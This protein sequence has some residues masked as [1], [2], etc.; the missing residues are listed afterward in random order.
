MK[1]R[2]RRWSR[3]S[4]VVATI[5]AATV[6]G[7]GVA[8]AATAQPAITTFTPKSADQVTNVDV[9]RQHYL[10]EVAAFVKEQ[11]GA[12]CV[13]PRRKGFYLRNAG[14]KVGAGQSLPAGYVHIDYAQDAGPV[15]AETENKLQGLPNRRY[16]RLLIIQAWRSVSPPP[17]DL[18]LALCDARSLLPDSPALGWDRFNAVEVLASGGDHYT[19]LTDPAPQVHL[20]LLLQRWLTAPLSIAA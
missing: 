19:M 7:G 17:Q 8:Y 11:L 10:D 20:A 13:I 18:P 5:V 15:L 6:V 3:R 9:L 2:A 16:S 4:T 12:D 14:P 1:L